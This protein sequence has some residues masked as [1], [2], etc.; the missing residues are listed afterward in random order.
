MTLT[1]AIVLFA[2]FW[3]M[4]MLIA[5]P[6]GLRTH[7]DM[8]TEDADTPASAPVNANVKRKMIWVTGISLALWVPVCLLIAS[9]WVSVSDLDFWGRGGG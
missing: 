3:F 2:V 7:G 1:G 6:L 8:G 5:L 4:G 9:G